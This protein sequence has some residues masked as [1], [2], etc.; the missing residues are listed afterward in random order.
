MSRQEC[1][2]PVGG[3]GRRWGHCC[4]NEVAAAGHSAP[5]PP[6]STTS[7]PRLSRLLAAAVARSCCVC[8]VPGAAAAAFRENPGVRAAF[9]AFLRVWPRGEPGP[10][11]HIPS[12]HLVLGASATVGTRKQKCDRVKLLYKKYTHRGGKGPLPIWMC[13]W[14]TQVHCRSSSSVCLVCQ[15]VLCYSSSDVTGKK[16]KPKA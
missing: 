10:G 9:L 13:T 3:W 7:G 12:H 4:R 16:Q 15:P 2:P 8:R 6:K 14:P 11:K 1:P 5:S